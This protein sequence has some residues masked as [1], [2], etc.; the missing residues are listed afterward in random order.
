MLFASSIP[1][2]CTEKSLLNASRSRAAKRK[3]PLI[4]SREEVKALLQ[5]PRNLRHRSLLAVLYGA[6]LRVSEAAQLKVSDIDSPRK[7]LWVRHGKGRRDRQTLLSPKLVDLLRS[8]WRADRPEN[9]LFPGADPSHPI[10]THA[11]FLACRLAAK[12][13]A[14]PS[15]FIRIRSGTMPRPG[16]CRVLACEPRFMGI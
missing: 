13:P 14:S 10:S 8:Y 2:L 1:T 15:P 11:I 9:W 6:G 12:A 3:L 16:L 7:V 5:A 4:L